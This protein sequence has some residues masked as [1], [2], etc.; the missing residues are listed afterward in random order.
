MTSVRRRP[1]GGLPHYGP[2]SDLTAGHLQGPNKTVTQAR[3]TSFPW[4]ASLKQTREPEPPAERSYS[5]EASSSEVSSSGGSGSA[6][7]GSA[8]S[9][10]S[11][12]AASGSPAPGR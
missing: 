10:A 9:I 8:A 4:Y 11:G 2:S 7:P 12:S 5:S 3:T 6:A 1:A